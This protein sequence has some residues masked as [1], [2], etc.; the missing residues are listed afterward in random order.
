MFLVAAVV[1]TSLFFR[2]FKSLKS[3]AVLAACISLVLGSFTVARNHVYRSEI[4]L[5]EDT[6]KKSPA[7]ARAYNN[8]GYAY[9]LAGRPADA[10][11]AYLQAIEIDPGLAHA[12][13][14]L[15]M[16]GPD[17]TAAP[18]GSD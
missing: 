3:F 13:N 14:N 15:Q 10:R 2:R 11:R 18:Q 12:V 9:Y 7:N 5:W 8:L 4:A 16:L 6:V 17:A 1:I